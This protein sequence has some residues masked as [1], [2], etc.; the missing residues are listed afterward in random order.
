MPTLRHTKSEEHLELN[1]ENPQN[2]DTATQ[3]KPGRFGK[4]SESSN[5][6]MPKVPSNNNLCHDDVWSPEDDEV[7]AQY[8]KLH[9]IVDRDTVSQLSLES[10][11]SVRDQS[12]I[13]F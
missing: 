12:K 1:S 5:S 11:D 9:R 7:T 3:S 8:L 4:V 10:I 6:T 13:F 2:G